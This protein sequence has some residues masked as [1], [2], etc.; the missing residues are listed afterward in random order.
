MKLLLFGVTGGT[1]AQL[2]T[3]A[4]GRHSYVRLLARPCAL[5][6]RMVR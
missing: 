6:G 1:G 4:T 3:Q 5:C 2:L